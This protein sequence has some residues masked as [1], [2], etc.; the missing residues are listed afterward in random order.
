MIID[1]TLS[2]S[3]RNKFNP[4]GSILR[5]YQMRLLRMLNDFDNL[6]KKIG[7]KYWL[8]G[9]SCLGAIRHNGFIPWDDDVDV[10]MLREDYEKLLSCFCENEN[11]AIQTVDNDKH[12]VC[13]FA[14]F[15]DKHSLISES[16]HTDKYKYKGA[17]IDIFILDERPSLFGKSTAKLVE[18]LDKLDQQPHNH[19]FFDSLFKIGKYLVYTII[20]VLTKCL[21][22]KNTEIYRYNYGTYFYKDC[23]YKS[24]V[25]TL[26]LYPFENLQLPVPQNWHHYLTNAFGN[27]LQLPDLNSINSVIH[28]RSIEIY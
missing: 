23:I 25:Q 4:E 18:I 8:S 21:I 3:L 22:K 10:E 2:K 19:F 14:K 12:Y 28:A 5:E 27:Y 13:A 6:C 20:K 1:D 7:V 11:Y 9:G 26:I 24:D 15:R 17:F 16:N